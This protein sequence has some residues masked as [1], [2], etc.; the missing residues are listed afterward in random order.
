MIIQFYSHLS[1]QCL[2]MG[3]A[4]YRIAGLFRGRNFP[5][6]A[7][8]GQYF[9]LGTRLACARCTALRARVYTSS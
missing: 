2:V 9:R 7:G 8:F 3:M 5:W 6:I 4:T 1:I